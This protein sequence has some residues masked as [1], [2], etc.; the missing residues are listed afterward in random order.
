MCKGRLENSPPRSN[1]RSSQTSESRT[2]GYLGRKSSNQLSRVSDMTST[3]YSRITRRHSQTNLDESTDPRPGHRSHLPTLSPA[4][5]LVSRTPPEK[6]ARPRAVSTDRIAGHK[7]PSPAPSPWLVRPPL[8]ADRGSV[9]GF[10]HGET[11]RGHA[12]GLH[13]TS[14]MRGLNLEGRIRGLV[15]FDL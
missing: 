8:L 10:L 9:A 6:C 5:L 7:L 2:T 12:K 4:R 3:T 13:E 1:W 11:P 15:R 14:P